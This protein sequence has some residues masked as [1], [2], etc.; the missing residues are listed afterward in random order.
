MDLTSSMKNWLQ[1]HGYI[2]DI[3]ILSIP[4]FAIEKV[5]N[6][7]SRS[8]TGSIQIEFMR[9][10]F[11]GTILFEKLS[12]DNVE[13]KKSGRSSVGLISKAI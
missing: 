12:Y 10:L 4:R 2:G 1:R 6:E 3:K 7:S 11:D 5:K 8:I 13:L 9:R